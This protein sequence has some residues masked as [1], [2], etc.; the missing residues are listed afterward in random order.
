MMLKVLK[1]T[2]TIGILADQ[3]TMPG[4]GVFV[5]FFG[6]QACTTTGIARVALHTDAAGVAGGGVWGPNLAEHR[7]WVEP[8]E[9][10]GADRGAG[11][12]GSERQPAVATSEA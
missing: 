5:D 4:E 1:E 12:D 7:P 3:N 9:G 10:C 6:K 8:P 11:R 2:G